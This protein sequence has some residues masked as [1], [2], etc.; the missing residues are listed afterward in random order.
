MTNTHENVKRL[1]NYANSKYR[2][3]EYYTSKETVEF[4]FEKLIGY[5]FIK[6]KI[7]YCPCDGEQ[8]EFVKYLKE[9]KD[10]LNYK[11][12]WY[13]S[14]DFNTHIDLIKNAD[15]VITNPPFSKIRNEYFPLMKK[16][17]KNYLFFHTPINLYIYQNE[18]VFLYRSDYNYY[19]VPFDDIRK[20]IQGTKDR[21]YVGTIFV[22]SFKCNQLRKHRFPKKTYNELYKDK[23]PVWFQINDNEKILNIDKIADI[24]IDY[25]E[26]MLVPLT[27]LYDYFKQYF[28]IKE[29]NTKKSLNSFSDSKPRFIRVLTKWKNKYIRS[30]E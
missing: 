23:E 8:S 22:S 5:E 29:Y 11:D 13:T 17:A 28:D 16:Y 10:D 20:P 21:V 14:D 25:N 26:P 3:D 12:F 30:N 1:S 6:D 2:N 27:I 9:K 4:I 24:P 18:E 7:I 15:L 19:V